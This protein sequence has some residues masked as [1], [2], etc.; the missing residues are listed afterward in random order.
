MCTQKLGT[1]IVHT[2]E[3][4]VAVFSS[5]AQKKHT[6]K[7]PYVYADKICPYSI[8]IFDECFRVAPA[9]MMVFLTFVA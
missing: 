7:V 2:L 4:F 1:Q 9:T 5:V 3:P 6:G 8:L